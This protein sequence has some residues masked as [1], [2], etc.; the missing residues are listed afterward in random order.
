MGA[1]KLLGWSAMRGITEERL[2]ETKLVITA[3]LDLRG[4]CFGEVEVVLRVIFD[5]AIAAEI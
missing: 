2:V 3:Y 4:Q 1:S 5:L